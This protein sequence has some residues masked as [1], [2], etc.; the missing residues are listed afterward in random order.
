MVL[1]PSKSTRGAFSLVE[2]LIAVMILGIGM[3]M[4][5]GAFPVGLRYYEKSADETI[6]G[7]LARSVLSGLQAHRTA[8]Y[9]NVTYSWTV[10]AE[11][12]AEVAVIECLHDGADELTYLW[13][14][15][16][17]RADDGSP[18]RV[19]AD[20]GLGDSI[21]LWLPPIERTSGVDNR[22][23]CHAFYKRMPNP[24]DDSASAG[25]TFQVFL[26]IQKSTATSTSALSWAERFPG[27]SDPVTVTCEGTTAVWPE[28][29]GFTVRPGAVLADRSSDGGWARVVDV[30]GDRLTL[31]R[32]LSGTEVIAIN[33][34]VAMFRGVVTKEAAR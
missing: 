3:V 19:L 14:A 15:A 30:Q 5:A 22:F 4:V 11:R 16:L 27:P 23:G 28:G 18:G 25:A 26:V 34:V 1:H 2:I 10:Q 9:Q 24:L 13:D 7:L 31:N 17:H 12:Y 21:D 8:Q 29:S 32:A 20:Q 33:N 6:A